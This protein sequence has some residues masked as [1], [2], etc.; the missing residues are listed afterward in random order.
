MKLISSLI[1]TVLSISALLFSASCVEYE[2]D[3][4]IKANGSGSLHS[5]IRVAPVL[6]KDDGQGLKGKLEAMFADVD[7]LSLASYKTFETED[8]RVMD[9]TI[10]FDHV[11]LLSEAIGGQ[12]D[13]VAKY[14]GTFTVEKHEDSY[15][16]IRT[17]KLHEPGTLDPLAK[18]GASMQKDSH[19]TYRMHFPAEVLSTN[20]DNAEPGGTSVEWT[21]PVAMATDEALVMKAEIRKPLLAKVR[22]S[23]K[24]HTGLW[25]GV[26]GGVVVLLGLAV[27][28][29]LRKRSK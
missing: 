17:V 9:F 24:E 27:V 13:S 14:F 18:L 16:M 10:V 1:R 3:F 22:D 12:G 2:E 28:S 26:A 11:S 5:V 23:V 19:L 21:F 15:T 20:A 8:R 7:G 29:L 25:L 6:S 4:T